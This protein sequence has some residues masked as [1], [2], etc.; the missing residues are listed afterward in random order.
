MI[1]KYNLDINVVN[2]YSGWK[3]QIFYVISTCTEAHF[4][5]P[6]LRCPNGTLFS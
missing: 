1:Q 2:Y 5:Q 4:Q 6:S 3:R